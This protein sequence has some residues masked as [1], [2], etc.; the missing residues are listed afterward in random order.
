M[1]LAEYFAYSRHP[2]SVQFSSVAASV[3]SLFEEPFPTS[4]TFL[5]S[6]LSIVLPYIRPA[7]RKSNEVDA[8]SLSKQV[9]RPHPSS[10][11][12]APQPHSRA[13]GSLAFPEDP[14]PWPLSEFL[15]LHCLSSPLE[16]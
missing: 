10:V 4:G 1:H 9:Y 12:A 14:W 8:S 2:V 15:G 3:L 5:Q 16:T 13:A 7:D 11:L 6:E